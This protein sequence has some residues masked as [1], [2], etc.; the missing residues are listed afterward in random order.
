[1]TERWVY[2]FLESAEGYP[3]LQ[4]GKM[5]VVYIAPSPP[6]RYEILGTYDREMNTLEIFQDSERHTRNLVRNVSEEFHLTPS[7]EYI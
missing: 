5:Y 4:G 6:L 7:V 2:T 1:M 3:P